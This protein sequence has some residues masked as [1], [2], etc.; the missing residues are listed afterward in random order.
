MDLAKIRHATAGTFPKAGNPQFHKAIID[1]MN[2]ELHLCNIQELLHIFHACRTLT[3]NR[4][5]S[6]I[7]AILLA[8]KNEIVQ[9]PELI[10]NFFYTYANCR[11]SKKLRKNR[12]DID[13][14]KN[15]VVKIM[16]SF[17]DSLMADGAG[18]L[19]MSADGLVRF[20]L[21]LNLLRVTDY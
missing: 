19:K 6:K 4:I 2:N 1:I 5:Q 13:T 15:E 20:S 7:V 12:T 14:D 21:A 8:R 11:L 3:S 9:D 17:Y 16:E 18:I 10:A